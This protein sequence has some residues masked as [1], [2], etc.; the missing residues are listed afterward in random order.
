MID[1]IPWKCPARH[2]QCSTCC[3]AEGK[4]RQT[5][6]CTVCFSQLDKIQ[7]IIYRTGASKLLVVCEGPGCSSS[8]YLQLLLG[9]ALQ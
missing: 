5:K 8:I 7:Y 6:T 2:L 4:N 1:F 9:R 3:S